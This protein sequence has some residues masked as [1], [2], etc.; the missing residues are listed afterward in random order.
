MDTAR[1][2][3]PLTRGLVLAVIFFSSTITLPDR[4]TGSDAVS[5]LIFDS[6]WFDLI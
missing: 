1:L 3:L 6:I 4:L 2:R 5:Y